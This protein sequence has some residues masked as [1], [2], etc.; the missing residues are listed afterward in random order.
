MKSDGFDGY[1]IMKSNRNYSIV[2][3][4]HSKIDSINTRAK[5]SQVTSSAEAT[6]LPELSEPHAKELRVPFID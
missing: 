4:F 1:Y 6:D 5:K 3:F 2:T